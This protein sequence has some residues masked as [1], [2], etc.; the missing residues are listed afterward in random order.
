MAPI[1]K[2]IRKQKIRVG[3]ANYEKILKYGYTFSKQ[4]DLNAYKQT[5]KALNHRSALQNLDRTSF[6]KSDFYSR[7]DLP[8]FGYK[9]AIIYPVGT[10]PEIAT[11]AVSETCCG[12][13]PVPVPHGL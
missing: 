9:N 3:S 6:K 8:N 11:V 2:P 5:Q 10:T 12:I 7:A 4:N 13:E 1:Q